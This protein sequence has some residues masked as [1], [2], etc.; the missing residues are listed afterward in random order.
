MAKL[1]R[2]IDM[3]RCMGCR[4]CIAACHVENHFTPEAPWNVMMEYEVGR[5]PHARTVFA[6]MNCMHCEDPPC[7]TVCDSIGVHAISKNA[8]GVVLIDY[9]TCIG[10]QYCA[11]VCPYGVPQFNETVEPLYPR[12][13]GETP[14]EQIPDPERHPTHR[15]KAHVVEKCTFCWH[16]LE[17]AVANGET[18]QI[19][20]KPEYTPSC[21]L[22]CPV[23][24]RFFGD[25]DDPHSEVAK[26]I[27]AKKAAQLKKEYGTR[28]QVYYVLEGG[29]Y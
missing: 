29:D 8:L 20:R 19:G 28:P 13:A 21:D 15:K 7:M 23:D 10:C 24:A 1:V 26:R 6:T 12:D 16:K 14:Y 22:V 5:Y 2:L 17:K 4:A 9:D 11:A 3:E 27:G 25:V 18:D